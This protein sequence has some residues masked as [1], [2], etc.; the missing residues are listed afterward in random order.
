MLV[1][2]SAECLEVA[3]V[4][5]RV[6]AGR[7]AV[8]LVTGSPG[9]GKTAL[10][11]YAADAA[12]GMRVLR[13]TG[14]EFE[15]RFA[16]SGLHQLL[17]PVVDHLDGLPGDQAVALRGALRLGRS[18]G[19]DPFLVSLGV[20]TLL[21]QLAE[22][23]GL[24][25]LVDD[26]QWLDDQSADA[27]RFAARRLDRDPVGLLVAARDALAGGFAL[28]RWPRLSLAGL[29]R[30]EMTELLG[31]RAG[32]AV[33]G[34]VAERLLGYADGNPLALVEM[35]GVLTAE[36]LTGQ[37]PLPEL[38]PLGPG[39]E[40]AFLDQVRRLTADAQDLLLI[41]AC[42]QGA[43]WGQV[44]AAA[45]RLNVSDRAEELERSGLVAIEAS[46]VRFR[47]PL[48]R[49]AVLAA[50]PFARRR[51][52][53]L[54]LAE[55]A[56]GDE[57]AD[58]RSWHRA[59]ACVGPDAGVADELA[60]SAERSRAR[61]GFAA[62]AAALQRAAELSPDATVRGRRLA[63]AGEAALAAGRPE[64]ALECARRAEQAGDRAVSG[65]AA[66]VRGYAQLRA[67]LLSQAVSTLREGAGLLAGSDPTA[68]L[69]MLAAAFEAAV[70]A[71]DTAG[72]L[73]AAGQ[74]RTVA[75][76][77]PGARP[78]CDLLCGIAD[79]LS[80]QPERGNPAVGAAI[81]LLAGSGNVR[82]MVWAVYAAQIQGDMGRAVQLID[83]G[84]RRARAS[85]AMDNLPLA[86]QGTAMIETI[87][88]R[89]ADAEAAA[90][91][92]LRLARETGQRPVESLNL[93]S[94]ALIA[95]MR[96][97]EDRCREYSDAALALA[98]PYGIASAAT[99]ASWAVAVLDLGAGRPEDALSQ[100]RSLTQPGAP[101]G[102]F[103]FAS[104]TAPDL[105]EA[106]V[107]CGDI[108][109]AQRATTWLEA[110][111]ADSPASAARLARCQGLI[112]VEPAESVKCLQEA[113]R[114]YDLGEERPERARTELLLGESL[115]RAKRRSEA[116]EALRSA[117]TV[118]DAI[119]ARAWAERARR[120]LR[121][122]GDEAPA[123]APLGGL[124]TLTPQELQISRLV[125]AGAS[126]REV[127]AQ[128]FLS[129]RTVEYHLYKVYPKLGI[130]S[131]TELARLVLTADAATSGRS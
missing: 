21:S 25:C 127:A 50:A 80:G 87:R 78:L 74:A 126:N 3:G 51:A 109:T 60:A 12:A 68:A 119:G 107:R 4:L 28:D 116:R 129:A 108:E 84:A 128:L 63:E 81:G 79:I 65:R 46:A 117:L 70:H 45:Q 118:F 106:A 67:G 88:G 131:R 5:E 120:E 26:A 14:A 54:A 95:A 73:A 97:E 11:G 71:G 30:P 37:Q 8:L 104:S 33:A 22:D 6:R 77:P 57:H 20:L 100:L 32:L 36:Q 40:A 101:A 72:V 114:L 85:G 115:R 10:L 47:H 18:T 66:A 35:V 55:V 9:L 29:S 102:H 91:E 1:G 96:G 105:V 59:E 94:L 83:D 124:G 56:V 82:W 64:W 24:V 39:L 43:Q 90:A 44:L 17:H 125:A 42:G 122:L 58:Q 89:Y 99:W 62:A 41:A 76:T 61:S 130:G 110:T 52:V 86:L 19:D 34:G 123:P 48:V 112:A 31:R 38:M 93:V 69:E 49:S 7:G 13:A 121:A 23:G 103:A 27:L 16:W 53:H 92:G 111:V 75:T 113:L 15:Q 2:R 98:I